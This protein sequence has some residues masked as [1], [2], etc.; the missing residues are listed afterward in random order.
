MAPL[1]PVTPMVITLPADFAVAIN[2]IIESRR[3]FSRMSSEGRAHPGRTN[4][5]RGEPPPNKTSASRRTPHDREHGTPSV[6]MSTELDGLSRWLGALDGA[7]E[8]EQ[9]HGADHGHDQ[10]TNQSIRA[11]AEERENPAAEYR[12]D[13]ADDQVH[14]HAHARAADEFAG[15]EAGENAEKDGPDEPHGGASWRNFEF[16]ARR[17]GSRAYDW[18]AL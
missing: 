10:L 7:D 6:R 3:A 11:E 2:R 5:R 12:A 4:R 15:D 16:D 17:L 13:D 18:A 14:Q 8:Q 9:D 1:A